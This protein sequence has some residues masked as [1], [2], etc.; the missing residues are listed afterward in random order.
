MVSKINTLDKIKDCLF[1]G[2]DFVLQG[3]AGCGKT[4]TLKQLIDFISTEYPDKKIACITHT[5]K[6][7]DEI[8]FRIDG[9]HVV[10]TIHS[11]LNTL[12]KDYKKNIHQVI[13]ELFKVNLMDRL[14]LTN[15]GDEK[16]QKSKE[17]E[18][19]KNVYEKYSARYFLVF[20]GRVNKVEGKKVYD[21]NPIEFNRILNEKILELNNKIREEI[22]QKGFK[23]IEYNET[24]FNDFKDLTFGHD[25]LLDIAAL[26][27]DEYPLLGKIL[28]DKFDYI[29][30][31]EYQDTHQKI[32][33]L[34][35]TKLP[36]RNKPVIGLFGDS[37]QS[38][39]GDGIGDVN[40]YVQAGRLKRIDK[41]D[42]FRCSPQVIKFINTL[43]NDGLNQ[44][45]A[46]KLIAGKEESVEARQGKVEFFYSIYDDKPTSWSSDTD[47]EAYTNALNTLIEE[48]SFNND[49]KILLLSNKA[50][51]IKAGFPKLYKVFSDRYL[52]PKE[53][54]T[55]IFTR[56]QLLDLFEICNA[57]K[58]KNHNFILSKLKKSGL[59]IKT[60][61]DKIS[62]STNIQAIINSDKGAVQTVE[63]AFRSKLLKESE[64]YAA[65]KNRAEK[66][67][68]EINQDTN[69]AKFE[70]N[71]NNDG[72]TLVKMQKK[73]PEIDEDAF[74]EQERNL[75][76]KQFF[77]ALFSDK[78]TFAEVLNYFKYEDEQ[79][80]Y[81]SMHKT[82][83]T[84]I[85]NVLVVLDEYF[86]NEY[87]FRSAFDPDETDLKKKEK[88]LQLIYV[89][90]SRAKFNLRCVRLVSTD[91]ENTFIDAFKCFCSTK[92]N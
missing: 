18:K 76:Q 31:D 8:K 32:V 35:L 71:Y 61:A 46:L 43:R 23:S 42:N 22:Q 11:F 84:G 77:E 85:D 7:V 56:L 66:F 92:I 75:K 47:K 12:I 38:I 5:N 69:F 28:N 9:E 37:M 15:Y 54:F 20:G 44:E 70:A 13:Y 62:I 16:E 3:G 30:I 49:S 51:S 81:I 67:L 41:E 60:V 17:H 10:S 24:R 78:V 50:V 64:S 6:A 82:K 52:E 53:E 39:Y 65:Y 36:S 25:G 80:P 4:E 33:D 27:I 87:N 45:L 88:N 90:C 29:F 72:H 1:N 63:T 79:T 57:Y 14:E 26:L 91:E 2:H 74:K 19:Y 89:A 55:K 59:S 86:W 21:A 48:A 58:T 68:E 73:Q 83:G 34:F 40:N